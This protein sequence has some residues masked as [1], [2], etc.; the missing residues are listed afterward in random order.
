MFT[1]AEIRQALQDGPPASFPVM[2]N[3]E[4]WEMIGRA[5]VL[6][7]LTNEVREM[8]HQDAHSVPPRL[9]YSLY[10]LF[11]E[12]GDRTNYQEAYF[13]RRRRL[14]SLALSSLLEN[15]EELIAPLEDMLWDICEEFT[16]SLPAH[17]SST[18]DISSVSTTVDLMAAETAQALA[19]IAVWLGDKLSPELVRR[20]RYE[21]DRRVL[22]PAFEGPVPFHWEQ[23][24]HNW[25]AV[26][27][28]AAGIAAL[29]LVQD[30]DRLERILN[31]VCGS[32][33]CFVSGYGNDG[34]CAEGL[35]YWVYGFGYYVYFGD[36]LYEYTDGRLDLLSQPKIAEIAL[37]PER[38]HF[39][40]GV[41]ANFSDSGEIEPLPSGLLSRLSVRIQHRYSLPLTVP[42]FGEDP[43]Y[44]WCHVSR[45]L[46]WTKEEALGRA[47]ATES[48][49]LPEL[50]WLITRGIL[51]NSQGERLTAGLAVKGGHND[52]PHNHNDLGHVTVHAGGENILCDLG[53]GV[54]TKAYFSDQRDEIVNI[55]SR[56]HSVP[57]INGQVQ[58]SGRQAASIV[59]NVQYA[60]DS[61]S[62]ALDLTGAYEV[63]GLQSYNR[64]LDWQCAEPD[65]RRG[66]RADSG[67]VLTGANGNDDA[68]TK[69]EKYT[70]H[71]AFGMQH[72]PAM[73]SLTIRD[74]FTYTGSAAPL[75]VEERF[76]SCHR[77]EVTASSI[78]WTGSKAEVELTYDGEQSKVEVTPV[79]HLDHD[80]HPFTFYVTA[81]TRSG[82][83]EPA[84]PAISG[85][86]MV[87][88]WEM[89]V[90]IRAI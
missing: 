42:A 15:S 12:T 61:S 68:L 77:P 21:V 79:A 17:I 71:T 45:N 6:Q 54:Y 38:I 70:S 40:D 36:L 55:S 78:C 65:T 1:S 58:H 23:A 62:I 69:L 28:G 9:T 22:R 20:I 63:E 33:A 89:N 25:A 52:E 83:S 74:V 13:E 2:K 90:T 3:R 85:H 88:T 46:L 56:Y 47:Q 86:P 82:V 27:A 60:P 66:D 64:S 57:I 53:A 10:R 29:L 19:E 24:T 4:R 37:F 84:D 50:A 18:Q 7:A 41:S 43:C 73:A 76:I 32:M 16:W 8:A 39:A 35:G 51:E 59:L 34:G 49:Y 31:R 87:E 72:P 5:D 44:R 75:E 30:R 14:A 67:D 11:A 26:C 81:I 80:G 48:H